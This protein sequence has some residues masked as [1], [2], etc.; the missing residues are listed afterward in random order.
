LKTRFTE[1][2]NV[3]CNYGAFIDSCAPVAVAERQ[4]LSITHCCC[5]CCCCCCWRC[6]GWSV[7]Q[8]LRRNSLAQSAKSSRWHR[9]PAGRASPVQAPS[10]EDTPTRRLS[11]VAV[12]EDDIVGTRRRW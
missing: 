6:W 2:K 11:L 9:P 10:D 12:R 5:C 1:R 4:S 7:S 8:S 3:Y